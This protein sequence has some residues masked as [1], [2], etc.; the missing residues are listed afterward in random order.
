MSEYIETGS[1]AKADIEHESRWLL[2]SMPGKAICC[3]FL[4]L[5]CFP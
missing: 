4:D 5:D 3:L 1:E 2:Q